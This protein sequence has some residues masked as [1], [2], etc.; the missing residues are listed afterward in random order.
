MCPAK[1]QKG[2]MEGS[3]MDLGKGVKRASAKLI[4][5]LFRFCYNSFSLLPKQTNRLYNRFCPP[6]QGAVRQAAGNPHG[7]VRH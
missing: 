6:R 5:T 2:Y 7:R 4:D 3:V 1:Q